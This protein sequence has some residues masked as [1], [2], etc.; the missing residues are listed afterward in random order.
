MTDFKFEMSGIYGT[1]RV[2]STGVKASAAGDLATA[3]ID[4]GTQVASFWTNGSHG[5]ETL[6]VHDP[7]GS[8][9]HAFT[10]EWLAGSCRRCGFHVHHVPLRFVRLGPYGLTR[11]RCTFTVRTP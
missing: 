4:W 5:V 9:H 1:G 6:F 2:W 3:L 10:R 11:L 8:V 7:Q